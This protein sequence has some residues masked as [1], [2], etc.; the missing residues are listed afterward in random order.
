MPEKRRK[1]LKFPER[2]LYRHFK[3][4]PLLCRFNE[5]EDAHVLQSWQVR[6]GGT[7]GGA[8]ELQVNKE[9][10]Y[11]AVDD[12]ERSTG[13][14]MTPEGMFSLF[15]LAKSL[16]SSTKKRSKF[17]WDIFS[18]NGSMFPGRLLTLGAE[19]AAAFK[20]E[21]GENELHMV[22]SMMKFTP[23]GHL[24]YL[25]WYSWSKMMGKTHPVPMA[26]ILNGFGLVNW[27]TKLV[28]RILA[29]SVDARVGRSF[30]AKVRVNQD[31]F[32]SVLVVKNG[33]TNFFFFSFNF[34]FSFRVYEYQVWIEGTL[35]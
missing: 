2:D 25:E 21:V 4:S 9:T 5:A 17:V 30:T 29:Q 28:N 6:F 8:A 14:R 12:F 32:H 7:L 27:F 1:K 20:I 23:R 16:A 22:E 24:S 33:T 35:V 26:L 18:V 10:M 13:R 3:I 19:V 11:A 31:V 15:A 34:F